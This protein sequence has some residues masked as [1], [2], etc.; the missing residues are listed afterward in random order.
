MKPIHHDECERARVTGGV[1]I[2]G[3]IE[4]RY[5]E[6]QPERV[7][8]KGCGVPIPAEDQDGLCNQCYAIEEAQDHHGEHTFEKGAGQSR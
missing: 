6:D 5:P 3:D 1:C 4:A 8:C 2:C 7:P